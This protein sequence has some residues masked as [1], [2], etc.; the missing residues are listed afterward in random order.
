MGTSPKGNSCC[1]TGCRGCTNRFSRL[2]RRFESNLGNAGDQSVV[3]TRRT[4]KCLYGTCSLGRLTVRKLAP[5]SRPSPTG[6]RSIVRCTGGCSV[7]AVFF[8]RLTDPGITGAITGRIST[9]ATILGPVRKLDR[10]SVR[11]KRSCF[12]IVEG[13]LRTLEGT[14]G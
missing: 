1:R 7:R 12:S 10:R 6:V 14:L 5:S 8:R 4:F 3:I 11:T 2:S 9:I 13:G